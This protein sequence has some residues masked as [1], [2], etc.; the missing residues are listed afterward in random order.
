MNNI[1][2]WKPR[3]EQD[4]LDLRLRFGDTDDAA[5]AF[6][7]T[8]FAT[9]RPPQMRAR[10]AYD[11][12][13][14]RKM[15]GGGALVWERGKTLKPTTQAVW[16]YS[17]RRRNASALP[18][19]RGAPLQRSTGAVYGDST[20]SR[21]ATRLPW[22]HGV[23]IRSETTAPHKLLVRSHRSG[24][25]PWQLGLPVARSFT[26][27]F[28]FLLP[29]PAAVVLPWGEGKRAGRS[30][31]SRF[32]RGVW[33]EKFWRIP[34][35]EAR[36]PPIGR[37]PFEPP[38]PPDPFEPKFDADLIFRCPMVHNGLRWWPSLPLQFGKVC[39]GGLDY[40]IPVLEVYFVS[41]DVQVVRLPGREP[42]GVKNI[43]LAID[44][45]SWTWGM[46]A[47][48]AARD[49]ELIEPTAAGLVEVEVTINGV[50]WIV[51]VERYGA[52][53]EFS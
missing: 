47:T 41:N 44:D 5:G 43:R 6:D 42:I 49:F 19:Q 53:R 26:D 8:L 36:K 38:K 22:E 27:A 11:N 28:D 51:L 9:L 14:L 30:W 46:S 23:P 20:R 31:Q 16:E 37:S 34:W 50:Q 24:S 48:I 10:A 2:F 25:L 17:D 32:S 45:A 52:S 3:A 18:W 29:F 4:A 7:A 35:D 21:S 33:L 15:V 13:V 1:R 12:R 40:T 39:D